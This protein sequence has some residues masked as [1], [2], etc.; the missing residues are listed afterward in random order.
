M[1]MLQTQAK[2]ETE[3]ERSIRR[4]EDHCVAIWSR[5]VDELARFFK[6]T[7]NGPFTYKQ[8][9]DVLKNHFSEKGWD[10]DMYCRRAMQ[11]HLANSVSHR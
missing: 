7:K 4:E 2:I 1:T 11:N 10:W 8:F 3:E 5:D 9:M 6:P